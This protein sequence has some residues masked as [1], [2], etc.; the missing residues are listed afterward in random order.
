ML[1]PPSTSS[2]TPNNTRQLPLIG[3]W[4]SLLRPG[5]PV[6]WPLSE[7]DECADF[8]FGYGENFPQRR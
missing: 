8:V 4:L 5:V 6:S 3:T 2:V 1:R 7:S